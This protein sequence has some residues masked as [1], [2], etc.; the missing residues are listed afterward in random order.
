MI[1]SKFKYFLLVLLSITSMLAFG[2]DK[3]ITAP[4]GNLIL[5]AATGST[6]KSN[7]LL[8]ANSGVSTVSA[9]SGAMAVKGTGNTTSSQSGIEIGQNSGDAKL[10]VQ[11]PTYTTNGLFRQDAFSLSADDNLSGGLILGARHASGGIDFY[12]GG[13]SDSFKRMSIA[14]TGKVDFANGIGI[15]GGSSTLSNYTVNTWTPVISC[16]SGSF[17][18]QSGEGYYVRMGNGVFIFGKVFWSGNDGSLSGNTYIT[19]PFDPYG[20][21]SYSYPLQIFSTAGYGSQI[22][23]MSTSGTDQFYIYTTA[24]AAVACTSFNTSGTIIFSGWIGL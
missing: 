24:L 14:S 18:G 8:E 17:T 7:K 19:M 20:S 4:N 13:T 9:T 6:V 21:T 2:V 22:S 5:D 11:G 15:A 16:N 12:A 10:T 23:L 1:M 3:K